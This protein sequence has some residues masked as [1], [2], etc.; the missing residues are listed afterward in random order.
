M[1]LL[2]PPA[3]GSEKQIQALKDQAIPFVLI[4]RNFPEISSNYVVLNN[5]KAAYDGVSR[6]IKTGHK[7][8]G[9]IAYSNS[10][11]HMCERING[12]KTSFG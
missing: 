6:L 1:A 5:Y 3:E 8:I 7:K 2:S 11:E 4:D 12:Y 9:M 10:L